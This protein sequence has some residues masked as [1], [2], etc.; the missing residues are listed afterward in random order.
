MSGSG[1][2]KLTEP[3][4]NLKEAI[5]WVLRL[6]GRDSGQ[7]NGD[8]IKGLSEELIKLLDKDASEVASEVDGIFSKARS[9]LQS[10]TQKDAREAFMF[11]SYLSDI[12]RYGRTLNVDDLGHFKKALQKDVSNPG[13]QSG[14][15]ISKLADGLKTLIGYQQN[16]QKPNG[17]N[18][19]G[20]QNYESSYN[21][22]NATW[23]SLTSSQREDCA[24]IL[25]GTMPVLYFGLSYLYW[26]CTAGS[27][28][29]PGW[30]QHKIDGSG[31]SP[32]QNQQALKTFLEKVGF[33][34]IQKLNETKQGSDIARFLN[35]FTELSQGNPKSKS[36]PE[37]L[38]ELQ[39]KALESLPSQTKTDCPLTS[40][41]LLS[42]YFITYP[43]YT[44]QYSRP[45]TP[46]FLGYSGL[47]A[48]AG[49]AYGFNLGGL[50][51]FMSAL[52]A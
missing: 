23:K 39:K 20:S 16:G 3:P 25:L 8:A 36:Y 4:Q 32:P 48:L 47:S 31:G 27:N 38:G 10:A 51:T 29:D 30:S 12:T 14:G 11:K 50:G 26:W 17:T 43:L 24:L 45:G 28:S 52:L 46:S 7:E 35:G 40:L 19:I 21:S 1:P 22:D 44:V 41:Y 15:P 6:S 49:G 37:F 34:E 2:K 13:E 42:Y 18:G 9:G 5:D 33:S